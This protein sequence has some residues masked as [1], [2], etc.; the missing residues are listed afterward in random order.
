MKVCL[1]LREGQPYILPMQARFVIGA[2]GVIA[3]S[4][5]FFDYEER[6]G[7]WDLIPTVELFG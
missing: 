7:A 2:D 1:A 5:V 6:T 3:R 4:E